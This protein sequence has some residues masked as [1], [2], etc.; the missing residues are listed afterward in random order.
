[1]A[2]QKNFPHVV[3]T[4]SLNGTL[5]TADDT[6]PTNSAILII[7][8][9]GAGKTMLACS[10]PNTLLIDLELGGSHAGA[11]V[12]YEGSG[13]YRSFQETA[14]IIQQLLKQKPDENGHLDFQGYKV[15]TIVIDTVDDLQ[16]GLKENL[17]GMYNKQQMYGEMLTKITYDVIR[18]AMRLPINKIFVAHTGVYENVSEEEQK[19]QKEEGIK[20]A[21]SP[22]VLPTV[23]VALEGG[24]RNKIVFLFDYV[25]HVTISQRGLHTL[26]TKS[27]IQDGQWL[28]AKDRYFTFKGKTFNLSWD[29]DGK[30]DSTVLRTIWDTIE[31]GRVKQVINEAKKV[32]AAELRKKG[33]S[34]ADAPKVLGESLD[35]LNACTVRSEVESA[36]NVCIEVVRGAEQ[37]NKA[38]EPA[39][40]AEE[41]QE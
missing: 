29:K 17:V 3:E 15:G 12:R 9:G 14:T 32:I 39:P 11:M 5:K 24:I 35:A 21:S 27:T 40:K 20:D 10:Q 33:Y 13:G 38:P 36:K 16:A 4:V 23:T 18:P 30:I 34:N 6:T 26:H 31:V 2:K 7:G 28:Y 22:T 19:K 41:A 37:K 1:M 8:S 25:L